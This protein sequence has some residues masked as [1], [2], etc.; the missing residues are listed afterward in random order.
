MVSSD[1][2]DLD[3]FDPKIY[4]QRVKDWNDHKLQQE[5]KK[6]QHEIDI[7]R[8]KSKKDGHKKSKSPADES[9]DDEDDD[10]ES[11]PDDVLR[12][13]SVAQLQAR[14]NQRANALR[15]PQPQSQP[16][17]MDISQ[18]GYKEDP[19]KLYC[20]CRQPYDGANDMIQCDYCREWYH[21]SCIGLSQDE[22]AEVEELKF[23]CPVCNG[24]DPSQL[25]NKTAANNKISFDSPKA[26]TPTTTNNNNPSQSQ[27]QP[28]PNANRS[29]NGN[30]PIRKNRR[31]FIPDSA[32]DTDGT[33]GANMNA[34]MN[35]NVMN[36]NHQ[37]QMKQEQEAKK[38]NYEKVVVELQNRFKEYKEKTKKQHKDM[39]DRLA[40]AKQDIDEER[41]LRI[42]IQEHM[43]EAKEE[44]D[45]VI[46]SL[47]GE[48]EKQKQKETQLVNKLQKLEVKQKK[49]KDAAS[50]LKKKMKGQKRRTCN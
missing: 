17:D 23:R 3:Q 34:S 32:S 22:L 47:A 4:E 1:D 49:Y 11:E 7:E 38:E 14:F 13:L 20:I 6:I 46:K 10:I 15:Q 35:V 2:D 16:N 31:R 5:M 42:E 8:E 39:M 44:S 50:D 37:M 40:K 21:L 30:G 18:S 25:Q 24:A 29:R 26:R 19:S 12:N 27:S 45:K 36:N 41:R 43:E 48:Y 33:H 9:D 28:F